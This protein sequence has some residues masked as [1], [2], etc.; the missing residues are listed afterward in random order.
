MGIFWQDLEKRDDY[1]G[2]KTLFALYLPQFLLEQMPPTKAIY[3]VLCVSMIFFMGHCGFCAAV[4]KRRTST[5]ESCFASAG[6][7]K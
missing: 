3:L 1:L 6:L 7:V 5:Y 2:Q 4:S